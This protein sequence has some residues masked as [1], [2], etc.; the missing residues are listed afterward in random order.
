MMK[1][2]RFLSGVVVVVMLCLPVQVFAA[3]AY[4]WKIPDNVRIVQTETA[5]V[6]NVRVFSYIQAAINSLNGAPGLVKVMPGTYNE[7]ITMVPNIDLEGSG[8]ENTII[9][10]SV[11]TIGTVKSASNTNI[12]NIKVVNTGSS[13][14]IAVLFDNVTSASAKDISVAVNGPGAE[15]YGIYV[16]GA[17]ANVKVENAD[18]VSQSSTSNSSTVGIVAMQGLLTVKNSKAVAINGNWAAGLAT[19]GG[20]LDIRDSLAEAHNAE[21]TYAIDVEGNGTMSIAHSKTDASGGLYETY[22]IRIY[23]GNVIASEA[24]AMSTGGVVAGISMYG[25]AKVAS[26]LI[27]GGLRVQDGSPNNKN[28]NCWDENFNPIL[29]N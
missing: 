28:V 20:T 27:A 4:N 13:T 29:N 21:Y 6:D 5:T 24:K 18:V 19:V 1:V 14:A 9:T 23:N 11:N 8:I 12:R 17:S 3:V 7:A 22:G 16:T 25:D 26:T 10:S 2:P 15:N